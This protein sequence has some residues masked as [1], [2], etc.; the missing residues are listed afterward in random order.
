[1]NCHT[2]VIGPPICYLFKDVFL[3]YMANFSPILA[4]H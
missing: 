2:G 1:M 3:T 4:W